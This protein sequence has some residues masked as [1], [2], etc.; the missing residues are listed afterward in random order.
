MSTAPSRIA[1]SLSLLLLCAAGCGGDETGAAAAESD[2]TAEAPTPSGIAPRSFVRSE[3]P[4]VRELR[5]AIDLLDQARTDERLERVAPTLPVE[6]DL[7]RARALAMR[8]RDLEVGQRI[9]FG[10]IAI[11]R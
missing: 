2:G 11:C 10:A 1:L 6:G 9:R 7:L 4:E 8:G 5:A 3:A